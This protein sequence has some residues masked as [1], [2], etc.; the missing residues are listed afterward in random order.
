M[1][2][3]DYLKIS[4]KAVI[5]SAANE[6]LSDKNLLDQLFEISITN[7]QPFAWRGAWTL[8][9]AAKIEKV[10]LQCYLRKILKSITSIE[11]NTQLAQLL[12]TLSFLDLKQEFENLGELINLCFN[13]IEDPTI[14]AAAR[15]YA[16]EILFQISKFEPELKGELGSFL[17]NMY[18]LFE[19]PS[20][21]AKTRNTIKKLNSRKL[22]KSD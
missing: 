18:P 10:K 7:E 22:R 3:K 4:S 6:A 20:T 9:T 11:Q 8:A 19:E 12:K 2:I 5:T 13:L 15:V 21:K 14:K 1:N 17:E 16:M